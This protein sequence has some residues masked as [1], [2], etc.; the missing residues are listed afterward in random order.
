MNIKI[1]IM[2]YA[3]KVKE[4]TYQSI[5][6]LTFFLIIPTLLSAQDKI[7][8][9]LQNVTL[10]EFFGVIEKQSTYRFSYRDLDIKDKE[11]VTISAQE[12]PIETILQQVF[13]P[14]NLQYQVRGNRILVTVAVSTAQ[15]AVQK[16]K[17]ITGR[18]VD[19]RGE[20]I[21]GA[22]VIEKD[23][24]TVNGTITDAEG[25]FSLKIKENAVIQ[26]S[27][28]GYLPQ[29]IPTKEK[30]NFDIV[31]KEDT[32]RLD[33]VVVTALGIKRS[34]KAL[35]YSV[36]K[37]DGNKLAAVKNIDVASNL[38]GKVA[39][40]NIQSSTE[41]NEAPTLK[42]RGET[43]LLV[44]DGIPYTN[45]SLRDLASDD[46][47]SISVLKGATAAALYGSRGEAGAILVTTK[48]G[49]K[50]GGLQVNISSNTMFEAGYLAF[51]EVQTSYSSGGSGTYRVGDFVWGAPLDAG[52]KVSQYNPFTYEWEETELVSKG[53]NN[54][55]NFLETG[56]IT[57]NNIN[58]SFQR[59]N[60]SFRTSFTHVYNKGQYPN[61]KLN[62]FTYS[63]GGDFSVDKFSFEG[64]MTYNKRFFPN[65]L[66]PRYGGGGYIYN[67]VVWSGSE[68]D[69]REYKDYWVQSKE[70]ERQNWME[71]NWYDNPYFLAHERLHGDD[72][73]VTNGSLSMKYNLQPWLNITLRSGFD[74]FHNKDEWRYAKSY[75]AQKRGYYYIDQQS[76]FSMNND[77]L[78]TANHRFG[79]L[80]F[81]GL[82][83]GTINYRQGSNVWGETNNGLSIPGFYSLNASV[84]P[85]KTGQG[86]FKKQVNSLFGKVTLSWESL[87][88]LD[89]TA[90]NDW[91]STLP[92][93]TRSF[94]YPSVAGS[95]ILS[96]FI[97]MPGW[98]NMLKL[99]G[100]WTQNKNDLG[101]YE[102][103]NVFS[104]Q[105]N[106]WDGLT[107]AYYPQ[108]IRGVDLRPEGSRSYE[109]GVHAIF[110]KNRLWADITY[111]NKKCYNFAVKAD[112]SMSSGYRQ[113]F[114]NSEEER[115]RRGYEVTIGGIPVKNNDFEWNAL[116]N[117]SLDRNIYKKLDPVYSAKAPW[118][119]EGK[120]Y[121]HL[122]APLWDTDPQGNI[123]HGAN[124]LPESIPHYGLMGY[125]SPDWI[126]GLSNTF[127]YKN[128]SF[129]IAIDGSVGGVLYNMTDQ[130]MWYAGSHIKSDNQWRYDEVVNKKINYVGQG[131]KVVSGTINR[132]EYGQV[133]ADNRVYA[134]NDKEVSYE[135]YIRTYNGSYFAGNPHSYKDRTFFK[136]REVALN[137]TLP[138]T[139]SQKMKMHDFTVGL[140]GSNLLLWTKEFKY[141]DPDKGSENLNS[142]SMRFIGFNL[143]ATF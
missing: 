135:N 90:R 19:E 52:Y 141:S 56:I 128:I 66:G 118:I 53:K 83:G 40:M 25:K 87:F 21:I 107:A 81:D 126:W 80:G 26:I 127:I 117:W 98:L 55:K 37:V 69:I 116:F 122:S 114:V 61:T 23:T 13:V 115:E 24:E 86:G 96:E 82:V 92:R 36:Q 11:K 100:S 10:Q 120:R 124:G 94:F 48:R 42:L 101:I 78:L 119:K 4:K 32:R 57:N 65:N 47:E 74:Y 137:Y 85:A 49:N 132:D 104:V 18:V 108:E 77:L 27:Y 84:D 138:T 112:L 125:S 44:I 73:D 134:P 79:K 91:S 106:V 29:D 43:P 130:V 97:K 102:I 9:S 139:I 68:Y 15:N 58:L 17:R 103:N 72:F 38:I 50:K 95:L 60:G 22:N 12:Q 143:K 45:V 93:S 28:I 62:K 67:L 99:R 113:T 71:N 129:D 35:G 105:T 8:L 3:D 75:T 110:L 133:I 109:F 34:E 131:V 64:N 123:V 70:N 39:G 121:D 14:R 63:I 31:L 30:T 51:P 33:E 111:Y 54:F 41:F 136:L 88:F 16:S 7:N 140:T 2:N 6:F 89:M 76:G 5:F 142:P 59:E 20:S 46:V 1:N